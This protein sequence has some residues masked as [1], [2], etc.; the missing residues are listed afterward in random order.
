MLNPEGPEQDNPQAK[1]LKP[2]EGAPKQSLLA[3]A[4]A[5]SALTPPS[6]TSG[7][8]AG[9]GVKVFGTIKI[10]PAEL[11][12]LSVLWKM[13]EFGKQSARL[14]EIFTAISEQRSQAEKF[15]PAIHTVAAVIRNGIN[16]GIILES[17]DP[18][19]PYVGVPLARFRVAGA[20]FQVYYSA[21]ITPESV[22]APT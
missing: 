2:T 18:E 15:V 6:V 13:K 14:G 19:N 21:A 11:E 3:E 5:L 20:R 22:T 12:V 1:A 4:S 7:T 16:K 17:I 9:E 8:C 10:T